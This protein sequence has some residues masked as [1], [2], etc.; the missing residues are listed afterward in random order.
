MINS[1]QEF[2]RILQELKQ[3]EQ[4]RQQ[5]LNSDLSYLKKKQKTSEEKESDLEEEEA[6]APAADPTAPAAPAVDKGQK[7]KENLEKSKEKMRK[8][9]QKIPGSVNSSSIIEK[10]DSIR[11]GSSLKDEKVVSNL[12]NYI[13]SLTD[14][15]KKSLYLYLDSLARIIFAGQDSSEVSIPSES[16]SKKS[17]VTKK[18]SKI[19]QAGLPVV[20]VKK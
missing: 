1:R 5:E 12:K 19:G 8:E 13:F 6:E 7:G 11:A 3:S 18:P 9:P 17:S 10:I 2:F 4:A 14:S 15:Q 16:S 20:T